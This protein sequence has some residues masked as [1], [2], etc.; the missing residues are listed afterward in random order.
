M[1]KKR[2][3]IKRYARGTITIIHEPTWKAYLEDILRPEK[4]GAKF[5]RKRKK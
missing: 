4:R 5:V 3:K 1:P 2:R